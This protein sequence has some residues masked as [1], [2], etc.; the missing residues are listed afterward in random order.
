MPAALPHPVPLVGRHAGLDVGS[1]AAL[2]RLAVLGGQEDHLYVVVHR[3]LDRDPTRANAELVADTLGD[4]DLALRSYY[5]GQSHTSYRRYNNAD[6][7]MNHCAQKVAPRRDRRSFAAH[8][9]CVND[10]LRH[11]SDGFRL[12][13]SPLFGL[14]GVQ[15][16]ARIEGLLMGYLGA[17]SPLHCHC[18]PA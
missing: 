17:R 15:R 11:R 2:Q 7:C 8:H 12:P 14:P 13:D 4:H 5:I 16:L 3:A 6:L 9:R 10:A 1:Q 18:D